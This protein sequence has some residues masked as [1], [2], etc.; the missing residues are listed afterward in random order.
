MDE[1][2]EQ[3]GKRLID[4]VVATIAFVIFL[5]VI[6]AI[7]V[8]S[9]GAYRA[10]PLF[11]HRRIGKDGEEFRFTKVRTLPP[12]TDRYIDKYNVDEDA[13]P[14]IMRAIRR[15]HLDELPQL[16]YVVTGRMSLVGPRPEMPSL[17]AFMSPETARLRTSV[18]PG[19]TGL[20]QVST[21]CTQLITERPE[22]DRLY[23]EHRC[24]RLDVWILFA[25]VRKIV[26]GRT[27]HLYDVP[28]SALVRNEPT[29]GRRAAT[30]ITATA[31]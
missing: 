28:Q 2:Y 20:W 23:V 16:L 1:H 22:Y 24:I 7:A 14:A 8:L 19:V 11:T 9:A 3:W 6:A 18:S 30:P 31:D 25:T 15:S 5:P 13:I 4:A 26:L 17:H 12:A 10:W 21:H 27:T 29:L